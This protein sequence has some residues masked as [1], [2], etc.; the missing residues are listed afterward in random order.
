VD[1]WKLHNI[2]DEIGSLKELKLLPLD[3]QAMLLLRCL[4]TEFPLPNTFCRSHF[5]L[6]AYQK[7]LTGGFPTVE[8][9]AA[10][11]LLLAAPWQY[12][13]LNG[14][15]QE[16]RLGFHFVTRQGMGTAQSR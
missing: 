6:N 1:S 9:V 10:K 16:N 14:S 11:D 2:A 8:R 7:R 12:L 13:V 15:L 3:R 5:N 4:A